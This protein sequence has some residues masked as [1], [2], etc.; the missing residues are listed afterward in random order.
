MGLGDSE[1]FHT[2]QPDRSHIFS[3]LVTDGFADALPAM[4]ATTS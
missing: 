1:L 3:K 2:I 4:L